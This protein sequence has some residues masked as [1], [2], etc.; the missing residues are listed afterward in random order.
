[1]RMMYIILS[2]IGWI[3][4]AIVAVFLAVKLPRNRPASPQAEIELGTEAGKQA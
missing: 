1:M 4:A 2:V 3:W